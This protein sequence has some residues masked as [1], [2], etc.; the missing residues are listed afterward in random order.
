LHPRLTHRAAWTPHV[1]TLPI[2]EG[3]V[4]RLEVARLPSGAIPKPVWLWH[5]HTSL[6]PSE[7]DQ[8]WQAFLC[9]FGIEH[10]RHEALRDRVEVGDRAPRGAVIRVWV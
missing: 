1:G 5:S 4:I 10:V 6:D 7:V 9:R 3:T 8:L 2:I